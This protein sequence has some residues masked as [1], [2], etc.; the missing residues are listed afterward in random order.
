MTRFWTIFFL[1]LVTLSHIF[2]ESTEY[3]LNRGETLYRV[4]KKL[5]VPLDLLLSLNGIK[6]ASRV[7][8]GTKL[9]IPRVHIVKKGDTLYGI[10]R[11]YNVELESL[12][13]LNGL[14][15][16]YIIKPGERLFIP[17]S[18]ESEE[19]TNLSVKKGNI[20]SAG[21]E[22]EDK[23]VTSEI[24]KNAGKV[25]WPIE[26]EIKRIK[27]KLVGVRIKGKTGSKILSVSSGRVI[28]SNPYKGYG[29]VVFVESPSGYIYGYFGNNKLL[30][31]VGDIVTKGSEIGILGNGNGKFSSLIFIVYRNDKPVDV[32]KAPRM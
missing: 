27:G 29:K 10:S 9:L 18:G 22:K 30:V 15:A 8:A 19:F 23:N 12:L 1:I 24:A 16:N 3:R 26:G 14:N 2:G 11:M 20:S 17:L 6:D 13:K 32:F 21:N 28:W 25:Y 5:G 31:K 4:S 7:K